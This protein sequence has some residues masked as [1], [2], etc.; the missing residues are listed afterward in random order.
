MGVNALV[1]I[2]RSRV[3]G[4][5]LRSTDPRLTSSSSNRRSA[6]PARSVGDLEDGYARTDQGNGCVPARGFCRGDPK[7]SA[8]AGSIGAPFTTPWTSTT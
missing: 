2:T 4:Y 5:A 7:W 1:M 6:C 8:N 3:I